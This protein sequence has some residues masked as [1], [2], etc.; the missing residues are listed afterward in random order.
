MQGEPELDTMIKPIYE[1][2]KE[3]LNLSYTNFI[4]ITSPS[5][6][7][8]IQIKQAIELYQEYKDSYNDNLSDFL[9]ISGKYDHN[10]DFLK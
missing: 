7:N 1:Q 6:D 4:K 9:Q 2:F 8:H 5:Y 10:N 3:Q